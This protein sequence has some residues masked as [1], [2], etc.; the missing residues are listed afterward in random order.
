LYTY[1]PYS[2]ETQN[3]PFGSRA[4]PSASTEMRRPPLPGPPKP[5]PVYVATGRGG[6]PGYE[7]WPVISAS[8]PVV[9]SPSGPVRRIVSSYLRRMLGVEGFEAEASGASL[10]EMPNFW[11]RL[12]KFSVPLVF[13][14][15][16]V[17]ICSSFQ[18]A[19]FPSVTTTYQPRSGIV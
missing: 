17:S 5:L 18:I 9:G 7:A 12:W 6:K 8:R 13:L 10:R 16:L 19:L 2:S 15:F 11:M 4:R 14:L 3:P 1:G